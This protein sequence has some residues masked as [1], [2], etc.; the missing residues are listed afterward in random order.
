MG[1]V[2]GKAKLVFKGRDG[3]R[4]NDAAKTSK[5]KITFS[6]LDLSLLLYAKSCW[7]FLVIHVSMEYM[8]RSCLVPVDPYTGS[9][10]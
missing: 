9:L 4:F 8:M 5:S 3:R 7:F 1:E 2:L 6:M 10:G